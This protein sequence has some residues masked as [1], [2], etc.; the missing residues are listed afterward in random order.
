MLDNNTLEDT[1]PGSVFPKLELDVRDAGAGV[2]RLTG[3][4][5]SGIPG[6]GEGGGG[7]ADDKRLLAV[8]DLEFVR[9]PSEDSWGVRSSGIGVCDF[10]MDLA[11]DAKDPGC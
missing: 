1:F 10:P 8:E 6:D 7:L 11:I 4:P 3:E 2:A 9:R 5:V